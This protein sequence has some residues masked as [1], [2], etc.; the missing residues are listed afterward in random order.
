[1]TS[2]PILMRHT[3]PPPDTSRMPP[4]PAYIIRLDALEPKVPFRLLHDLNVFLLPLSPLLLYLLLLLIH[5]LPQLVCDPCPLLRLQ[6][7]VLRTFCFD[8]F[9]VWNTL[10]CWEESRREDSRCVFTCELSRFGGRVEDLLLCRRMDGQ[11]IDGLV[12]LLILGIVFRLR[13]HSHDR[14][15][16]RRSEWCSL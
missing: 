14:R 1:M 7:C 16:I 15:G 6:V 9:W 8:E 2:L 5:R 13:Q 11:V 12:R 3:I 10:V 4:I